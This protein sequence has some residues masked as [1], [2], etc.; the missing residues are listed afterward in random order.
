MSRS[1][2]SIRLGMHSRAR[3]RPGPPRAR[4][5]PA[6]VVVRPATPDDVAT[7]TELRLALL[8]EDASHRPRTTPGAIGEARARAVTESQLREAH[9]H[10][11]LQILLLAEQRGQVLGLLRCVAARSSSLA[12]PGRHALVTT[13][14]VRPAHR[15]RGILRMLL[16]AADAWARTHRLPEMRLHCAVRNQAGNAAWA[17]LGF[18][19]MEILHRR[20]VPRETRTS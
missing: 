19:P 9:R 13:A 11:G 6:A 3:A 4:R 15:C 8:R 18:T 2:A 16:H 12:R 5:A 14:Y 1:G 7:V 20:V 10:P 17:A